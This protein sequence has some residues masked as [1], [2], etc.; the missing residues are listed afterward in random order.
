MAVRKNGRRKFSSGKVNELLK[1]KKRPLLDKIIDDE[2][3]VK[4]CVSWCK[5]NGFPISLPCTPI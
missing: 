5:K 4:D 1:W 2:V 3:P